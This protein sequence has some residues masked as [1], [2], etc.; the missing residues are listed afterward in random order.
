MQCFQN[1]LYKV[2]MLVLWS[3]YYKWTSHPEGYYLQGE[4][5]LL[6]PSSYQLFLYHRHSGLKF[7]ETWAASWKAKKP[8]VDTWKL[9]PFADIQFQW[10]K[11]FILDTGIPL[12]GPFWRNQQTSNSSVISK[13][14]MPWS[15]RIVDSY[16][17]YRL[18]AIFK[19]LVHQCGTSRIELSF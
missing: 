10:F 18:V 16:N 14:W 13:V 19:W 11:T 12:Q 7:S 3:K 17:D 4:Q 2:N 6:V 15:V 8:L 9:N 1:N 5:M